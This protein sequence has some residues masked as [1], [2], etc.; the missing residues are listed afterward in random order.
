MTVNDTHHDSE[1]KITRSETDL[2][3]KRT[4][5]AF[6]HKH[7]KKKMYQIYAHQFQVR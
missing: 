6:I 3:K 2:H 1:I 4:L 7:K 5:A